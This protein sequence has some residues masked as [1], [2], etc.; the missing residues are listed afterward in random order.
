MFNVFDFV[1]ISPEA[2]ARKQ[3]T[4]HINWWRVHQL[5]KIAEEKLKLNMKRNKYYDSHCYEKM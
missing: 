2:A 3:L 4:K 1:G 5:C